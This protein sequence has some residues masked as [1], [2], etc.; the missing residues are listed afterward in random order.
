MS[1]LSVDRSHLTEDDLTTLAQN[2]NITH[3]AFGSKAR[4]IHDTMNSKLNAQLDVYQNNVDLAFLRGATGIFLDYFG[5]VFNV[6]RELA[7]QAEVSD[8]EQNIMFYTQEASFGAINNGNDIILPSGTNI[9]SSADATDPSRVTYTTTQQYILPAAQNQVFVSANSNGF[10]QDQNV[11]EN[12][13]NYTDFT[14]YAD[15]L[16]QS[17]LVTNSVSIAYGSDATTDDNYR[18]LIKQQAV[19]GEAANFTA[20]NTALLQIPGV[21]N[22]SRILYTRGIGT[23][24]WIIQATTPTISTDLLNLCQTAI[25]ENVA[26]GLDHQALAP[27]TI[28]L[29]LFLSITYVGSLQDSVKTQINN[30]LISNITNYVNNIGVGNPLVIDQLLKVVLNSSPQIK[31]IG[32]FVAPFDQ[33]VIYKR[34][35]ISDTR[36]KRTLVGDYTAAGYE[37]VIMEPT[38]TQ[39][40]TITELN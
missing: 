12:S 11:G 9:F 6:E 17:L 29:Q 38:L 13:L 16:N 39:P 14:N 26:D 27:T 18:F 30:Q 32:T 2:T 4:I 40:I 8:T 33:I 22:V 5:E 10:G 25:T 35:P 31:S 19:S 37:R 21:A 36:L 15:I 23:A 20:I 3:L 1:T 7:Q 24:D 34:S 28:G